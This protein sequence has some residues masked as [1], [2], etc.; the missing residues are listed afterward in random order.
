V[1]NF[2]KPAPKY[3]RSDSEEEAIKR[4]RAKKEAMEKKDDG[5]KEKEVIDLENQQLNENAEEIFWARE[6]IMK[7]I[8]DKSEDAS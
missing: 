3:N 5:P 7:R 4:A 1:T 2:Y 6:R 8:I